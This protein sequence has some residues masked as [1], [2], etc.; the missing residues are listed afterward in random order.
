MKE[1]LARRRRREYERPDP[2]VRAFRISGAA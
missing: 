2:A 1:D